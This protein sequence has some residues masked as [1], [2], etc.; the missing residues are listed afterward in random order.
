MTEKELVDVYDENKIKTNKIINRNDKNALK[1]NEYILSVHCWII[2][3]KNEVLITQ[4]S[5][6]L[7]R[8]GMW[9]DT[10]GAVKFGETSIEGMKREL[11]EELGINIEDNELILV[12]TLQRKNIFRDCYVILKI[13][14]IIK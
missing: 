4:R 5:H 14:H 9:E 3:S 8:G 2:N 13:L 10:H 6:K 1:E 12:T 11:N 7:N